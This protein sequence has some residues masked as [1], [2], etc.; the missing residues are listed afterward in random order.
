MSE[1]EGETHSLKSLRRCISSTYLGRG[2][3]GEQ[4]R[5]KR[6]RREDQVPAS[7][8]V[9]KCVVVCACVYVCVCVCV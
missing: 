8:C 4:V 3:K 7:V 2:N 6:E 5:N 1:V 9:V